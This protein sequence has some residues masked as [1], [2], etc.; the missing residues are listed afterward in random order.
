M[1]RDKVGDFDFE[2]EEAFFEGIDAVFL[3]HAGFVEEVADGLFHVGGGTFELGA[4]F[5]GEFGGHGLGVLSGDFA[6]LDPVGESGFGFFLG[7]DG[8]ADS[9]EHGF[10]D[11]VYHSACNVRMERRARNKDCGFQLS[12]R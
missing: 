8:C 10:F 1:A 12:R 11:G 6:F 7:D 2:R 4:S 3:T 5:V 9:G